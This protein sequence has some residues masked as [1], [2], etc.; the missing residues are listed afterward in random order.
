MATLAEIQT[1]A[2]TI[3][4]QLTQLRQSGATVGQLET[5]LLQKLQTLPTGVDADSVVNEILF[6]NPLEVFRLPEESKYINEAAL[7]LG[8]E[9]IAGINL[10]NNGNIH[11]PIS[12][13]SGYVFAKAEFKSGVDVHNANKAYLA[14]SLIFAPV[15]LSETSAGLAGAINSYLSGLNDPNL[16]SLERE[17]NNINIAYYTI[18]SATE[19]M[20]IAHE[21]VVIAFELKQ[22]GETTALALA[23]YGLFKQFGSERFSAAGWGAGASTLARGVG[24]AL[25]VAG[26]AVN[27][28]FWG[29]QTASFVDTVRGWEQTE[30]SGVPVSDQTKAIAATSYALWTTVTI[31]SV[32]AA[33]A[34]MIFP[35]V[36]AIIAVVAAALSFVTMIF[37]ALAQVFG[38]G[39]VVNGPHDYIGTNGDDTI[40]AATGS[41]T[42]DGMGGNDSII[43]P[44]MVAK[45][46]D[47]NQPFDK[48]TKFDGGTGV[49]TLNASGWTK[50]KLLDK[51]PLG[52][53][54]T[55]NQI[56]YAYFDLASGE[57][58]TISTFKW[59][60]KASVG[61]LANIENVIGTA[62]NDT[63]TG[64]DLDNL[65]AGYK[66]NDT[67]TGGDG[68]DTLL[69]G[70]GSDNISGGKH[71]DTL[72]GGD[73]IDTLDGGEGNDTANYQIDTDDKNGGPGGAGFD[74]H[75]DWGTVQSRST[76]A[77]VD[78]LISIENAVGS[79]KNDA[80]TGDG[81]ANV[82]VGVDGNDTINGGGGNDVISGGVGNDTIDGGAD[83]DTL[84]L[85]IDKAD[86][87]HRW[88]VSLS[89]GSA[90]GSAQN[91]L[92]DNADDRGSELDFF[93]NIENV[94][95]S[96]QY[97]Y[98]LGNSS[99]NYING[100]GGADYI[101]GRDGNDTLVGGYGEDTLLGGKGDDIL[102][103]GGWNDTL[104]GGEGID[105]VNFNIDAEDANN[106]WYIDLSIGKSYWFSTNDDLNASKTVEDT[107]VS[108]ENAVGTKYAD[109]IG[110]NVGDNVLFGLGGNDDIHGGGGNDFVIGGSGD[111]K[112]YGDANND[113][114]SGGAGADYI[115]GGAD[116]NTVNYS[117]D[118]GDQVSGFTINLT[119]GQAYR[120]TAAGSTFEDTLVNIQNAVGNDLDTVITGSNVANTL[121]GLG[122][123]DTLSGLAGDDILLGGRGVDS[124]D[125]GSEND[126]LSGGG[127]IDTI[128]GG[129]GVD[130]VSYS[131]DSID[132]NNNW[133][134]DLTE[135]KAYWLSSSDLGSQKN[136]DDT[137]R[138][139]EN[140]IG[141]GRNNFI[142]GDAGANFLM[143]QG[144]NDSLDG[145][146]GDD[147]LL[148][149]Y[150]QDS[151]QGGA[152]RDVLS[153]GGGADT[154]DGGSDTDTVSYNIDQEDAKNG[155]YVDLTAGRS[156]R[157][158]GSDI[159]GAKTV[160]DTLLNIE[161]VIATNFNDF[162]IGGRGANVLLG[163]NGDDRLEGRDGEDV[164][165]GG[166]G[167]DYLVGG[168]HSDVLS[169]GAGNDTL[170]GGDVSGAFDPE[171]DAVNY[172]Q[173]DADKSRTW[174]IDLTT[175]KASFLNAS[176]V[177]VEED[178]LIAIRG[179]IGGASSDTIIGDGRD[180]YLSGA[181]GSDTI[182]GGDGN[183]QLIGGAGYDTLNGGAGDDTLIGGSEADTLNGGTGTDIVNY[184]DIIDGSAVNSYKARNGFVGYAATFSSGYSAVVALGQ[185]V[186]YDTDMLT[187]IEGFIG[188]TGNDTLTLRIFSAFQSAG[189]GGNDTIRFINLETS[190][191]LYIDLISGD[192]RLT[193]LGSAQGT[194]IVQKNVG[195]T[196]VVGT[197]YADYILGTAGANQLSGG[198][199][200][201]VL[202]G[203]DGADR[204]DGGLGR[205]FALYV[206]SLAGVN[207]DL[208]AGTASGGEATGDVLIAIQDLDGS[209]F[210]DQFSGDANDNELRGE[211]GNDLLV[212]R[213]GIDYL[214]GGAG[215]DT[216]SG[217]V[218]ADII[219]GGEGLDT[220]D[221][222]RDSADSSRNW[223]INLVTNA[224]LVNGLVE[225]TISNIENIIAGSGDDKIIGGVQDNRILGGAGNDVLNGAGGDD[226][227]SGGSGL[228]FLS[229]DGGVNTADYSLDPWDNSHAHK[230]D[231]SLVKAWYLD[232][233]GL[234]QLEDFLYG[235]DNIIGG[236]LADDITGTY[237]ANKFNGGGGDDYLRGAAGNDI[238]LGGQ[239]NDTLDG[240]ADIDTADYSYATTGGAVVNLITAK[241]SVT[242]ETG[243]D[244]LV[245][246][247]NL[248]GSAFADSLTGDGNANSLDGGAGNDALSGGAGNDNLMGGANDDAL[249]GGLGNDTI[250]GG[251][252]IDTL[253]LSLDAADGARSW[254]VD[255]G[256]GVAQIGGVTEDTLRNIENVVGGSGGNSLTGDGLANVLMGGGGA[257]ALN[258]GGEN[259]VLSGGLGNDTIDGGTGIDTL[260]LSLDDADSARKWRVNLS[261]GVA[262]VNGVT[263]DTLRNVESV[264]GG[265]QDDV[266][267]GDGN[268]NRLDGGAGN[269]SLYG[270]GGN[271]ILVGGAGANYLQGDGGFDTV[272][273]SYVTS[274]GITA[275]LNSGVVTFPDGSGADY[276]L[277]I[278]I[279]A[280]N[281][282][283]L[284]QIENVE[285][286]VGT[287]FGDTI[288]AAGDYRSVFGGVADRQIDGAGGNDVITGGTGNDT[289]A[290][291]LGSDTIDGGAGTDTLDLTIDAGDA[292]RGFKVD[293][294]TGNA[295]VNDGKNVVEDTLSNIENVIGTNQRD[296]LIG[297]AVSNVLS[298]GL[299]DDTFGSGGGNDT[300]NGGAG[301]DTVSYQL[302]A[303]DQ[304][305]RS[306]VA[307][308]ATGTAAIT[309]ANGNALTHSFTSIENLTG[310][311]ANDT[312]TGDGNANTLGGVGGD[313]TLD[314]AAGN[315]VLIGGDGNDTFVFRSGSGKDTILDFTSGADTIKLQGF[316]NIVSF[317]ALTAAWVESGADVVIN[318]TANDSVTLS[319]TKLADLHQSDFLFA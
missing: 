32:V 59:G 39:I 95:G 125:G 4:A 105:T 269:D 275:T 267:T 61:K 175:G 296:T 56:A 270:G 193:G 233:A 102:A 67:I 130:T 152:G 144:G 231:L 264:V 192:T 100:K 212:G 146:G 210:D 122:G 199:G 239:G 121:A 157:L 70:A 316:A 48:P 76:G 141:S 224:I 182:N 63:I 44:D 107:L 62:Y 304:T 282:Q 279:V 196:N 11:G 273:Y 183:D 250:D 311:N 98:I 88:I 9:I 308:L 261:L 87:G 168:A 190:A 12:V 318:L 5:A 309:D 246:I 117:I 259:D 209:A 114:M 46:T 8:E 207:I 227:L 280:G 159:N 111:D 181:D 294:T 186:T 185:G 216:L 91:L 28:A 169:G 203:G 43:L 109:W 52:G 265:S 89:D 268:A 220:L 319:H 68:N 272:D 120:M 93:K 90:N 54:G 257:D 177:Y 127:E 31:V 58:G 172:S 167:N 128:D 291:G 116:V 113:V 230:I 232:P 19:I 147:T 221:L 51:S 171:S 35:P 307:N 162:V 226:T 217:G 198:G 104:N 81:G 49:D 242:G 21:A 263:E 135:G 139:I 96:D 53:G 179:V 7:K 164:L 173:D 24:G 36:G 154:V 17:Q 150:G 119:T 281:Q 287:K 258:G 101:E 222:S 60:E 163:L 174:K 86:N 310:S 260:N 42:A 247:E 276:H 106:G 252:G 73:G 286:I 245:N 64:N 1:Q 142:K 208:A 241:G 22:G 305:L 254:S 315:D 285:A 160:E 256:L 184:S 213:G 214:K 65:L 161:S 41:S 99:D 312:L 313:D 129:T 176:N 74:I 170:I 266:L 126:L 229:G 123:N 253:N 133:Y 283:N 178:T 201:D 288:S 234:Y 112:L 108:I 206:G 25:S 77:V 103:G 314:G 72:S 165:I 140:V 306:V 82:L 20:S 293:L 271:D 180:N 202:T 225:D 277:G 211:G 317:A 249:S 84:D 115:D 166:A 289:L 278:I 194:T 132:N 262:Q 215:N 83:I 80:I 219:D 197:D 26:I 16:T 145:A 138:N 236:A 33:V 156:Y 301:S 85:S 55:A 50:M 200:D 155:W 110:G 27:L 47:L 243:M 18:W 251:T 143:A 10:V 23:G 218:G 240:G 189:G 195:W 13:W 71:D 15:F 45:Y 30:A 3:K 298:G 118:A 134:I 79:N 151:L 290:G 228:D 274:G 300:F 244:T 34:T 297:N 131:L 2:N 38:E 292:A 14:A 255:L 149:G 302:T 191:A 124:L 238:L 78:T 40:K 158:A 29:V 97:D 223:N 92:S 148:G 188:S 187:S 237:F 153:G 37:D 69:G 94:V 204:L 299:N 205:N 303:F 295:Y 137:L 57:F 284:D 75:L 66:G 235:I 6:E 136:Y 248:T